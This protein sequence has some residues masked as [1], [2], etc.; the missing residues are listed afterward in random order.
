MTDA[1][2]KL[3]EPGFLSEAE[4]KKIARE[5]RMPKFMYD[6]AQA[7]MA[8]AIFAQNVRRRDAADGIG[9]VSSEPNTVTISS[10]L[11]KELID[12]F[13]KFSESPILHDQGLPQRL[14]D[15]AHQ[16]VQARTR[17]SRMHDAKEKP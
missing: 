7:L 5:Q 3:L 8:L 6:T 15:A 1:A 9:Y 17:I 4:V 11:Y 16:S 10:A 2:R 13:E 12:W 14:N